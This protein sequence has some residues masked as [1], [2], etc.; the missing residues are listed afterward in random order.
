MPD[1]QLMKISQFRREFF[2]E[3]SRPS[4]NTLKKWCVEG[5][6]DCK[7]LGDMTYIVL[8]EKVLLPDSGIEQGNAEPFDLSPEKLKQLH[9]KTVKILLK[10]RDYLNNR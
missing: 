6:L 7:R 9:P 4:I 5:S 2:V 3:G 8:N 1:F 10:T